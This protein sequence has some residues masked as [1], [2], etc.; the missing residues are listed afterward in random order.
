MRTWHGSDTW[1][2]IVQWLL[3]QYPTYYKRV[4]QADEAGCFTVERPRRVEMLCQLQHTG[5]TSNTVSLLPSFVGLL[6]GAFCSLCEAPQIVVTNNRGSISRE[7]H[8]CTLRYLFLSYS[9]FYVLCCFAIRFP[10]CKN[11]KRSQN[12]FN[13]I[14]ILSSVL[15]SLTGYEKE[16]PLQT[17]STNV[18]FLPVLIT[19]LWKLCD[20]WDPGNCNFPALQTNVMAFRSLWNW[21]ISVFPHLCSFQSYCQMGTMLH[22]HSNSSSILLICR[23]QVSF[24][25]QVTL[26]NVPHVR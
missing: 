12:S 18:D 23:L 14:G 26:H 17:C 5:Q 6:C 9:T 3:H 7:E 25:C 8:H 15:Q 20:I 22:L 1:G 16:P 2:H 10:A 13:W 11:D 4:T 19:M 21:S 24:K